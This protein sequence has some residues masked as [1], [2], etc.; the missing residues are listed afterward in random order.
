MVTQKNLNIPFES[1]ILSLFYY[2]IEVWGSAIQSKYPQRIDKFFRRAYKF[3]YTLKEYKISHLVEERDKSLFAKIVNDSD[4][5]LYDLLLEK[6]SRFLRERE[7]SFT[8]PKIK[9]ERFK[10]SFLNR[11]LFDYFD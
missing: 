7:H 3:G 2:G 8:L 4:D 10:R 6:K 11:C 1:L 5:I 9:T